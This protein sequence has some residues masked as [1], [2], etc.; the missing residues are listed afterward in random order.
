MWLD[1]SAAYGETGLEICDV[2]H[3]TAQELLTKCLMVPIDRIDGGR[4]MATRVGIAMHKLGWRKAKDSAPTPVPGKR[5]SV[6]LHRYWRPKSKA[7]A[8]PLPGAAE[9]E[10]VSEF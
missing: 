3:F 4:A 9:S 10:V 5:A 1:S 2:E 7:P 8:Q 6:R